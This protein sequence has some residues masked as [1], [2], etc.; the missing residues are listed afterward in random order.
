MKII[1]GKAIKF[2]PVSHEDPKDPGAFKK[3]FFKKEDLPPGRIQMINWA[4]LLVGR[5]MA[6]H[7]HENMEEIFIIL[8]GSAM[9]RVGHREV[10]LKR[11]DAVKVC[12]REVHEMKTLGKEEVLY[13]V[14]GI[15]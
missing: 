10:L 3:V 5:T 1:R 2:V 9:F 14:I 11:G 12:A 4:K 7:A 8:H 6:A 13:I 15:V